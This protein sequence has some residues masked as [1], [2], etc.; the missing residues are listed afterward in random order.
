MARIAV[1]GEPALLQ[2]EA[3]FSKPVRPVRVTG[4]VAIWPEERT[5]SLEAVYRTGGRIQF[6]A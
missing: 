6:V 5:I 2:D 4:R 3:M 1:V